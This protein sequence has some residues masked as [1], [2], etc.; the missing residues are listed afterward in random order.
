[1]QDRGMMN[2]FGAYA[3]EL[4]DDP[5]PREEPPPENSNPEPASAPA[6]AAFLY[7]KIDEF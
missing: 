3:P 4:P 2:Y 7:P 6:L 1:M 5:N